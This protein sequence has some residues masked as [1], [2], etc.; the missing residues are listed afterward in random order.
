MFEN[1]KVLGLLHRRGWL[2][3]GLVFTFGTFLV[4][5]GPNFLFADSAL[6]DR[7]GPFLEASSPE[8]PKFKSA[9]LEELIDYALAHNPGWKSLEKEVAWA[10]ADIEGASGWQSPKIKLNQF[11][12][13]IETK[14][15]PQNFQV[16][17]SQSLPFITETGLKEDIATFKKEA[18]TQSQALAK[19]K[20]IRSIKSTYYDIWQLE[21]IPKLLEENQK[22]VERMASLGGF[23]SQRDSKMLADIFQAQAM[24]GE[25][26]F[27]LLEMENRLF[28]AKSRLNNLLGHSGEQI[29]KSV[30]N[31]E[32]PFLD[33][34]MGH[35]IKVVL[36]EHPSLKV[37]NSQLLA[38]QSG[39]SLAYRAQFSPRFEVALNYFSIGDPSDG[40]TPESAGKDAYSI[41]LG[42]TL[43]FGSSSA[44][45][46]HTKSL[47][48]AQSID[49]RRAQ[50]ANDLKEDV[51]KQYNKVINAQKL[52]KIFDEQLLPPARRSQQLSERLYSSGKKN[53]MVALRAKTQLINLEIRAIKAR[54]NYLKS[55]VQLEELV[56][57]DLGKKQPASPEDL[58]QQEG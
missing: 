46:N 13:P 9:K 24:I 56:G 42:M 30:Q 3:L 20:L 18:A 19:R 8:T 47:L 22:V 52:L 4:G 14:Y 40:S 39:E 44:S 11:I 21:A 51:I 50:K 29:V 7:A 28:D 10:E 45:A 25:N 53:I 57:R 16:T 26:A 17:L 32:L 41:S 37:M 58:T 12:E 49:L 43:P 27:D 38:A 54:A 23:E 35:L 48:K 1:F 36:S 55:L 2:Q 34:T 6:P 5:F 33:E 31:P 15:G